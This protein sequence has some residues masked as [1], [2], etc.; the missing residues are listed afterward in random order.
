MNEII[1]VWQPIGV[2]TN[3][4]TKLIGQKIGKLTSHTGTLDPMAEGVIIVLSG[5]TRLE[6]IKLASWK[7]TYEFEI[8]LGLK[9]DSYDGLGIITNRDLDL[10]SQNEKYCSH[11]MQTLEKDFT[12]KLKNKFEGK[13]TQT[14]PPFSAIRHKGK[15]LYH[16]AQ[17][18]ELPET[19]PEKRGEIFFIRS[20]SIKE[21]NFTEIIQ[22]ILE[23]VSKVE[24]R[25]RQE[26]ISNQW[27]NFINET[28]TLKAIQIGIEVQISRGMYV[29]SLAQDIAS[30]IGSVGFVTNLVRTQNGEYTKEHCVK[31]EDIL[32]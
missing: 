23:K 24:G 14:V 2:S 16:L 27:K 6:K 3:H 17:T 15:R 19:L 8:T 12:T 10:I 18:N 7:K 4:I 26:E 20:T 1:P 21:T 29:R 5:E 9:T 31:L 13:Y 28:A 25:L 11:M 22:N 32:F 30:F